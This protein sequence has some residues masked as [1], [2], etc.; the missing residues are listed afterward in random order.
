MSNTTDDVRQCPVCHAPYVDSQ[1]TKWAQDTFDDLPDA[2]EMCIDVGAYPEGYGGTALY[3]H[4]DTIYVVETKWPDDDRW[5]EFNYKVDD[6]YPTR[7]RAEDRKQ[8]I[9]QMHDLVDVRIR[10]A[11]LDEFR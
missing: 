10:E 3:F 9:N 6:E 8:R 5:D 1:S 2:A 11:G 4:G 7:E